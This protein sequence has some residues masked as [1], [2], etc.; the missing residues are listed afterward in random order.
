[1]DLSGLNVGNIKATILTSNKLQDQNTFE[2]PD[3][4]ADTGFKDFK[5]RKGKL[6]VNLPPF[7][8]VVLESI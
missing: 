7:S 4:I 8:V 6:E 1:M 2:D 5:L 3:K